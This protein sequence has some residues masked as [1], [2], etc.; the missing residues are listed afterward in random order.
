M[1]KQATA[2]SEP[3]ND[4]ASIIAM[5]TP[6]YADITIRGV[7]DLLFNGWSCDSIEA[8]SKAAKGSKAKKTDDLESKVYRDHDGDLCIP[9]EN[10]K[11][12][13]VLSAKYR[14]DPRS[15]RKSAMDLFKAGL[16]PISTHAKL[17]GGGVKTW[18]FEHRARAVVMRAGITRTRPAMKTGWSAEFRF[19]VTSP[20]LIQPE[21]LLECVNR[22]GLLVG[23]CDFR[24]TFGRFQV[25]RFELAGLDD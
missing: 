9:G 19:L 13:I 3:T 11:G 23:V 1:S 22:A 6:Y 21:I 4:A 7:A 25:T 16:V 24:P 5:D 17:N 20:D 14:Q 15:P 10:L 2:L 18:D 12:S 8:K